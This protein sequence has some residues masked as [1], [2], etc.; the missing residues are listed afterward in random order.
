M[1]LRKW[2]LCYFMCLQICFSLFYDNS[3]FIPLD[4]LSLS[5][6]LS[7]L[8]NWLHKCHCSSRQ[9]S[10][11]TFVLIISYLLFEYFFQTFLIL[12]LFNWLHKCHCSSRQLSDITFGLIISKTF[13]IIITK[14]KPLTSS[15]L[16]Y[17]FYHYHI[18]DITKYAVDD[19]N[20]VFME[21]T[22]NMSMRS[23]T[24]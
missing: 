11:I 14:M 4:L 1:K 24:H 10:D 6:Y 15:S 23:R 2:L 21:E 22:H 12:N 9:L 5:L 13:A 3:L 20:T 17:N 16:R 7:N 8:Y 18:Q 19:S